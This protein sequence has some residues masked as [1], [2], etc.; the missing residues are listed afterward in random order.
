LALARLV[1][2]KQVE[3]VG[4]MRRAGVELLAGTDVLNPSC[5]PGFSLHEELELLVEAGLTPL[6]ALQAATLNPARF[7]GKAQE[8]GTVEE[9]KRAD[10]VLLDANPLEAISNTQKI[11]AFPYRDVSEYACGLADDTP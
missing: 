2:Q 6:E 7:L 8:F 11:L 10:L 4:M 9:G 5:F 1:Y 3:L